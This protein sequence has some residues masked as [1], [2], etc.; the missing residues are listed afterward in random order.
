MRQW[1]NGQLSSN[2][3]QSVRLH[4]TVSDNFAHKTKQGELRKAEP[5]PTGTPFTLP[6]D[7]LKE[8]IDFHG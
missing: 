8:E 2:E 1:M 4:P 6:R 3:F 5:P 7:L